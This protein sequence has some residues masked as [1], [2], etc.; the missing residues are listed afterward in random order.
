[1]GARDALVSLISLENSRAFFS[2][3]CA[4]PSPMRSV[5]RRDRE[6]LNY[7]SWQQY[8]YGPIT[9]ELFERVCSALFHFGRPGYCLH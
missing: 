2:T 7:S 3:C 5:D 6:G 9:S 1:M 8:L 4:Y